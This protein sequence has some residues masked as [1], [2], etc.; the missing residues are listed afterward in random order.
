MRSMLRALALVAAVAS[1]FTH[2][3]APVRSLALRAAEE[4]APPPRSEP[5]ADALAPPRK[6]GYQFGDIS[7]SIG[8][9]FA[10]AAKKV[11]G[12]DEYQFGDLS[13]W[14]DQ[15]AKSK[16]NELTGKDE[17]EFGDV[18]KWLDQQAK[19]KVNELTGKDEYAFGDLTKEIVKRATSRQYSMKDLSMLL[20]A[21]LAFN[22]GLS[23]VGAL[24]PVKF[25]VD[26]LN[27]SLLYDTGE[28]LA[29]YA[30]V[31]ID[32]R[33]KRALTGDE[34]YRLG[35]LT[36][37]AVRRFTGKE[38]YEFG[39]VSRAVMERSAAARAEAEEAPATIDV[40][41]VVEAPAEAEARTAITFSLDADEEALAKELEQWDAAFLSRALDGVDAPPR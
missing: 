2:S 29:G 9:S 17:Y 1:A 11:T 30:A 22:V 21:L 8:R 18:S 36:M 31:E 5:P 3:S 24:L 26:L 12:K 32:K 35:D 20:K 19:G 15:Q 39:D 28:R 7:R 4:N 16:V 34:N 23:P 14:L 27:Y 33:M 38:N 25:L 13:R 10:D 40:E 41:A 37:R 6:Q